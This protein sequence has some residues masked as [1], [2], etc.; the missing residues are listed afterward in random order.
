VKELIMPR[1]GLGLSEHG[2]YPPSDQFN[3]RDNDNII[4]DHIPLESGYSIFRQ[5][6]LADELGKKTVLT[7]FVFVS[8]HF[9]L[10]LCSPIAEAYTARL[11]AVNAR[12]RSAF[13]AEVRQSLYRRRICANLQVMSQF[14]SCHLSV[15]DR[16]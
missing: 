9:L 11:E 3:I 8:V 15:L 7:T 14:L 1:K 16:S 10:A 6:I 13:F 2:V 12:T 5:T 4:Y